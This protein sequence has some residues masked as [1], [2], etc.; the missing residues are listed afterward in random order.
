MADFSGLV[1]LEKIVTD[2]LTKL[3]LR[4]NVQQQAQMVRSGSMSLQDFDG[5]FSEL[6]R[7]ELGKTLGIIRNKAIQK[8]QAA[9][10]G[11]AATAVYR[12]MYKKD[13]MGNVNISG[14][15]GRISS[16]TR[17]VPVPMGGR[18]GIMRDRSVSDRTKKI[19]EYYGPDR[20]F[21]LRF[22]NE[23]TDTRTARPEGPTGKGSRA[24]YGNR[25]SISPRGFFHQMR[26]DMEEAAQQLG[27]TLIHHVEE[28][29]SQEFKENE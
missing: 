6:V 17:V 22:L 5:M 18:S 13:Y 7:V 12:R 4:S 28:W 11:S 19:N 9:G 23:G 27:Q 3:S 25:A 26:S 10:A 15:R 16:K 1:N 24:T 2:V 8:A 14:N 21:I 20:H 29:V